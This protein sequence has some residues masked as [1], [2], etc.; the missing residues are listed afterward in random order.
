MGE[1]LAA[2]DAQAAHDAQAAWIADMEEIAAEME[3]DSDGGE[4]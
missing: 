1:E 2:V 3:A 4:L